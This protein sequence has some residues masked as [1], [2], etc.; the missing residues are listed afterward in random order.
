MVKKDDD[1]SNGYFSDMSNRDM[2]RIILQEIADVRR[3]LKGDIGDLGNKFIKLDA[4]ID[5]VENRLGKRIDALAFKVDKNT[6]CLMSNFEDH[7]K[8]IIKLEE[9]V[10]A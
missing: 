1:N 2:L 4:K 9:V 7:D 3:E 8:R 10:L 5:D 6:V